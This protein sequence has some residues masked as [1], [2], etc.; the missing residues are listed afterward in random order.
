MQGIDDAINPIFAGFI[1]YLADGILGRYVATGSLAQILLASTVA[2][3]RIDLVRQFANR[4]H[5][6]YFLHC[7]GYLLSLPDE[8]P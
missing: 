6:F 2:V 8:S 1:R 4:F 5:R 7:D 3:V